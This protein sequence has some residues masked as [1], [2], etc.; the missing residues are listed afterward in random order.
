[1]K[2]TNPIDKNKIGYE[3][4]HKQSDRFKKILH[5]NYNNNPID[6]DCHHPFAYSNDK[7]FYC[8]DCNLVMEIKVKNGKKYGSVTNEIVNPTI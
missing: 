8:P 3:N 7:R 6:K 2:Q 5:N 1:M 4:D